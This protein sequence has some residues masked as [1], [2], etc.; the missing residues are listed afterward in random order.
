M[1]GD[2]VPT[3]KVPP[4][5]MAAWE[6][7]D[8]TQ[9][10]VANLDAGLEVQVLERWG[11]WA[12]AVFSNGWIAWVDGALLTELGLAPATGGVTTDWAEQY[13]AGSQQPAAAAE[14]APGG[15]NLS[16]ALIP[17]ILI[18]LSSV[19]P[20]FGFG[21]QSLNAFEIPLKYLIDPLKVQGTGRGLGLL[22]LGLGIGVTLLSVFPK[23]DIARRAMAGG[24]LLIVS[25]FVAQT[26]RAVSQQADALI[27]VSL[28]SVL[29]F[30]VLVALAG[31]LGAQFLKPKKAAQ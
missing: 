19:F 9:P 8:P 25:G 6:S 11:A 29:G 17:G 2:F 7:P 4:G 30:G 20:W 24:A 26:Q 3:H 12:K 18:A 21:G 15:F 22:L 14:T 13:L 1:N 31:A 5:G 23:S 27:K 16:P 10:S 28:V